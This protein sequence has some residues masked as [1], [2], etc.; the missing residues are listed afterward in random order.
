MHTLANYQFAKTKESRVFS[1]FRRSVNE[2]FVLL[3][4]YTALLLVS[5]QRCGTS[6][7]SC[8]PEWRYWQFE[9]AYRSCL[10]ESRYWHFGTVC[11]SHLQE[12]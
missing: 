12:L 10:P 7:R 4:C 6:Y 1:G 3:G 9:T 8:L 5:Y 2:V 11:R